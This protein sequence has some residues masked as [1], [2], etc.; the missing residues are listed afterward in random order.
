MKQVILFFSF[1][2][3]TFWMSAQDTPE[4]VCTAP[5]MVAFSTDASSATVVWSRSNALTTTYTLQYKKCADTVWT[6]INNVPS[7]INPLD[8]NLYTLRNLASCQCY[9]VRVR[10][11]C[12]ATDVSDWRT[13]EFKTLGCVEPCRVPSQ[14][15][16]AARDSMASLNWSPTGVGRAYVVQWKSR[17]DSVWQTATS[18]TNSLIINRLHPC[19]E[20]QFRVKSACSATD[21]SDYSEAV[22]FKTSGCVAPCS[23]PREVRVINSDRSSLA[24]A[25]VST[26]AAAYEISYSVADSAAQTAT[27]SVNAFRLLNIS[28]CKYYKF[29]VRSICGT[30][31]SPVYSEWSSTTTVLTEGCVRCEAPG[32]L[33]YAVTETG[34]VVKW[35]TAG[36]GNITYEVQWMGP[37]DSTWRTV[38]AIRGNQTSLTGLTICTWYTVRV[39]A[40]CT[41]SSSTW[42]SPIRFQTKG[43]AAV[44]VA[45]KNL[46]VYIADTVGVISWTGT[47]TASYRL[48]VKS[49]DGSFV[50]EATVTSNV[51]TLTGLARCKKYTVQLKTVCS[52][53]SSSD[54]VTKDFE[55]KGC[56]EPCGTPR[57]VNIQPDTTKATIKWT[58]MNAIKYYIEYKLASDSLGVWKRDSTTASY[59][60]LTNLQSCKIYA[61]RIA[62]VCATGVSHYTNFVFTT[63]GCAVPCIAPQEFWSEIVNDTTASVKF[64]IVPSQSYTVQYRVAGTATWISIPVN[65]IIAASLPVRITGLLKCTSYQW[66]V[67]RHCSPTSFVESAAQLFTTK[68]CPTLCAAL[69]RDLVVTTSATDS[70]KLTWIMP[71]GNLV[72]E[73]RYGSLIDSGYLNATS[74]RTTSNIFTMRGLANCRY[75]VVQIRTICSTGQASDWVTKSFRLGTT[76]FNEDEFGVQINEPQYISE[77]GIYPNPGF[78]AVQVAYTLSKEA[79]VKVE[80]MN[81]QGQVINRFDGGNQEEGSYVQTLDNL[82]SLHTGVYLVVISANGKVVNTQ[83]WQKQ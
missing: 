54:I 15:F 18:S 82:S 33:S 68:G 40:N 17:A 6:S 30:A 51:Y 26:G 38:S 3:S 70:A 47:T 11:N 80:L 83:K 23:T 28:T 50:R 20:Y 62:A 34:A 37:R 71:A 48:V 7:G 13:K 77:F 2:L 46:K 78:E 4:L 21:M 74:I 10:A 41:G 39:K 66:R 81:L 57:E 8:S 22:K 49:D 45:P 31:A 29:K 67:L 35:D 44:C 27:V 65:T 61:I 73:V 64:N 9:H 14:L 16:A 60:I 24:I 56:P 79:N 76:C 72:Y 59:L 69:P 63:A 52:A 36:R 12:T 75:Y 42:S 53:T 55:T 5:D 25:W 1:F 19:S 43:C 32:R 58:N